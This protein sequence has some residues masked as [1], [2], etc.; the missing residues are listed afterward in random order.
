MYERS[1]IVLERYVEKILKFDKQFNLRSNYNNFKEL[2]EELEN[3]QIITTK[4]GKIIQEFED[5]V[6][7]IEDV[8]K[9][10]EKIY[11]NTVKLEEDRNKLFKDLDEDA[12]SLEN[13]FMKIELAIEKNNEQLRNLRSDY[14]E[15]VSEFTQRQKERNKCE[16]ERRVSESNHVESI[17]RLINEFS[18]IDV[19]DILGMKQIINTGKE[20]QKQE[21]TDIMI[22]NG[23]NEKVPFNQN[24]LK[25]AIDTRMNIAEKEIACYIS[26]YDKMRKVLAEIDNDNLKLDKYK[27]SLR[28]ISVKLAFLKAENE[29]IVGF[30]D[31]ER[32][33][34]ISGTK[35]HNKMMEEAC[36]NFELDFVQINNLYELIL[37][38]ISNK[39]TKKAYKE[40]YN[41]SYLK[42]IEDKEKNFEQEINSIKINM[43]TVINSNYWRIEG[44]KNIYD[45]FLN[46][47]TE[48]FERDLSEFREEETEEQEVNV[49][50]D[51]KADDE[52]D[53][54]D[55][56][57][58][59]NEKVQNNDTKLSKIQEINLDDFEFE[60]EEE[61][62]DDEYEEEDNDDEDEEDKNDEDEDEDFLDDEDDDD[63]DVNLDDFEENDEDVEDED[64]SE[65][66]IDDDFEIEES[67]YDIDD[68]EEEDDEDFL[69][70]DEGFDYRD[71]LKK[72]D[73]EID[74]D[75]FENDE[76]EEDEEEPKVVIKKDK[77]NNKDGKLKQKEDKK[78]KEKNN[79]IEKK[80]Q[81]KSA[82]SNKGLFD[83]IFKDKKEKSKKN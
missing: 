18:S 22:K 74:D 64:E 76:D 72:E 65:D 77:K 57:Q 4:E 46:E 20:K 42:N 70:E 59:P 34:A 68:E 56:I 47:V 33:T 49:I 14:I 37:R 50:D 7:R 69:G 62:F 75:F 39:A 9:E 6:R 27:K 80:E 44:I 17:K 35:M 19:N 82:K 16:K 26:I 24:V 58:S 10:Q 40:L 61:F 83:K 29:Y 25:L 51:I 8:Q 15:M 28:D 1:A 73:D 48:K 12:G 31:Y 21:I 54:E 23:K 11:R 81:N 71:L 45:V 43:G 3:Y 5:T 60:D 63:E 36:K 2:I 67:D 55:E 38:E 53:E 52:F 79:K 32:M 13:R 78:S 66:E 41:N 30:L